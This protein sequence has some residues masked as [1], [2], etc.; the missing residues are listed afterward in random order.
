[1]IELDYNF[2]Y[3]EVKEKLLSNV[4]NNS[5][6]GSIL[7]DDSKRIVEVTRS[8][9]G[10]LGGGVTEEHH[11]LADHVEGDDNRLAHERGAAAP[12]ERADFVVARNV[13]RVLQD[14]EVKVFMW[15]YE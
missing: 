9:P 7:N 5:G 1:M 6:P 15:I 3:Y 12:H 13:V 2:E 4:R 8:N 11:V 10:L 14:I